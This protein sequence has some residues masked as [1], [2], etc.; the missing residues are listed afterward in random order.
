MST[1][2][3]TIHKANPD[4]SVEFGQDELADQITDQIKNDPNIHI[5][6]NGPWGSGKTTV[7]ERAEEK[8]TD[9]ETDTITV[10]YEP[11]RYGP[12]QTTLRR[13]FL[14]TLDNEVANEVGEDPVLG[15]ESYHFHSESNERKSLGDFL[16]D[17]LKTLQKTFDLIFAYSIVLISLFISG[18]VLYTSGIHIATTIAGIGLIGISYFL[19][20]SLMVYLRDDLGS[21]LASTTTF[22]IKEPKINEID[23][24][25][26]KYKEVLKRASK[27]D[28]KIVVFIDDI[29]RCSN[30]EIREVITGLSTYLD[31]GTKDGD[32]GFIA[33][34]DERK[35]IEVFKSEEKDRMTG[36]NII[37]KTFQT[38]IPVPTLSRENI[39]ELVHITG[40]ELNYNISDADAER[41]AT[42]SVAYTNSN[43]RTI[44]SAI[45]EAEWMEKLGSEYLQESG[46]EE[47]KSF[48]RIINSN[49]NLYRIGLI[50]ILSDSNALREYVTDAS[51]WISPDRDKRIEWEL[52]DL[53]PEFRN[54]GL[55]PR[56]FF[57]LNSPNNRVASIG[58]M[59]GIRTQV[60]RGNDSEV[61]NRCK[62]YDSPTKL[63]ICHSLL[64]HSFGR[65]EQEEKANFI[66]TVMRLMEDSLDAV[67]S[68]SYHLFDSCITLVND[69]KKIVNDI[70]RDDYARW[71]KVA[72]KI[73]DDALDTLLNEQS[74]FM[75][76][77]KNRFLRKMCEIAP[78]Y[79]PEII[80]RIL[81][82]EIRELSTN[83]QRSCK[84]V[85]NLFEDPII[86]KSKKAP[87][88]VLAAIKQWDYEDRPKGPDNSLLVQ[89]VLEK[90]HG[91]EYKEESEKT[92]STIVP[93]GTEI[94]DELYDTN[95]P[96][97]SRLETPEE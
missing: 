56:P 33:A 74:A 59:S 94:K 30:E 34:I 50:K 37:S 53:Q 21:E 62:R 68:K 29:D 5:A 1:A 65:A 48:N 71:L 19:F 84:R 97:P 72:D 88:Y 31:P 52:F 4:N 12:D 20:T 92:Y 47:S 80:D 7:L 2:K 76:K 26:G 54:T 23:L 32:I 51:E 67:D 24:F 85:T 6:V 38:V 75:K 13:T 45:C 86:H 16:G 11:W 66:N 49:Y 90:L 95:W 8:V 25:E 9:N 44:R 73:G 58:N 27:E 63:N 41:I 15:E 3:S 10:W 69:D 96:K 46:Y 55:D 83:S 93:N 39:V 36:P 70:D 17:F 40:E 60:E 91:D 77:D 89:V 22:K 57:A 43:L 14:K 78:E 42:A 35:V 87:E 64:D 61:Q 82:L 18:L 28:K 81:E 79:D